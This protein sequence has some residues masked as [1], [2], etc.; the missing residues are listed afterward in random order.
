MKVL[1][2]LS[3][4]SQTMECYERVV[5]VWAMRVEGPFVLKAAGGESFCPDGYVVSNEDGG[6][7]AMEKVLFETLH[8]QKRG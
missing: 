7:V 8:K 2:G 6:L 4:S 3:L 1:D 5:R